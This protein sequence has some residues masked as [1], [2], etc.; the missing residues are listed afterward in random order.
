MEKAQPFYKFTVLHSIIGACKEMSNRPPRSGMELANRA[1]KG[2][3][4]DLHL[5]FK[6]LAVMGHRWGYGCQIDDAVVGQWFQQ[7][8]NPQ[9]VEKR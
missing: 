3:G 6:R 2:F 9:M 5:D 4:A 8:M 1:D 7:E